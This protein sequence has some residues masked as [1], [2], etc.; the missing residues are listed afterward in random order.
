MTGT[1]AALTGLERVAGLGHYLAKFPDVRKL[2]EAP[3]GD[4]EETIAK[5]LKAANMYRLTPDWIRLIDN[6]RWFGYKREF[7]LAE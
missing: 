5:R 3:Q 7:D 1:C 2:F 6:R 4:D